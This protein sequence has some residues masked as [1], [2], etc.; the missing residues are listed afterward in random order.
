VHTHRPL[1]IALTGGIASGK[2]AVAN[3]FARLGVPIVD[4]DILARQVVAP[5]Q[6]ALTAIIERFGNAVLKDDGN[7]DRARLRELVFNDVSQKQ[8]LENILHPAIRNAQLAQSAKL[9]GPYQIHVVPLLV[10][11]PSQ[12]RYDRILVVTCHRDTQMQ[13]LLQRDGIQPTLAEQ[14]LNA[15]VDSTQRLKYADDVI[16]NDGSPSELPAKVAALHRQ[17]LHLAG[18]P[19]IETPA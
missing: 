13:R 10:E 12:N 14:M 16:E 18:R 1:W 6:R 3:E 11:T 4:L 9:N 7:L 5:G 15:Q 2:S 19:T 8:A 17:Y